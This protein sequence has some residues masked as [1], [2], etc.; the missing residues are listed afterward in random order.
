MMT[1][2]SS[3]RPPPA[4][5]M[6]AL[7]APALA[8]PRSA[9]PR[10]GQVTVALLVV[11]LGF[12]ASVGLAITAET[13]GQLRARGG[14]LMFLGDLTGMAGTYLALV[15][16][17][18]VSRLP[19]VERVLG[20]DGLLRWHRRLSPWPISLIV[21]HAV[22]LTLAYAEATRTG[23]LAQLGAFISSYSGMLVAIVGFGVLVV[24]AIM[25]IRAIRSRLR[26]ETWWALHL[27]MYLAFALAFAHEVALGPSFVNHPL[28]QAL[29]SAIWA[30]TAGVVLSFRFGLPLAR[31]ARHGLRVHSTKVEADGITS[32]ILVGKKLERLAISGGQ[33]FE[34]RFLARGLWWQAHPYT[35]S[36]RPMPP[37]LRLTVKAVGDHSSAIARLPSGTRVVIEGPYG[38]FTAYAKRRE[39]VAILV[40]GIGVTA[41][42]ALLEDLNPSSQPHVVLRVSRPAEAALTEEVRALVE[43]RGGTLQVI[44]GSRHDVPVAKVVRM[45]GDLRR[46]DVYV[47]G[48]DG[49]VQAMVTGLHRRGVPAAAIHSEV[50]AL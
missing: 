48:P 36:A 20:Q 2:V 33:F 8:C 44:A 34:W 32:I 45:L 7:A 3:R 23:V 27:G 6:G 11:A 16:I 31:S 13:L 35:V 21:A 46:R 5:N 18:L 38:A 43:A 40:G 42:R 37:Y 47:A 22:L 12:G 24:V 28:T 15:M 30:A 41:A 50:Y 25:S 1:S 49:F 14:V 19:F 29:W 9:E 4:A 10:P 26:R 17:L 39:Q